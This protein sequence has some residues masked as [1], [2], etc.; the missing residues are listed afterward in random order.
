MEILWNV[1][2]FVLEILLPVLVLL[3]GWGI[4]ALVQ[5]LGVEQQINTEQL[6]EQIVK[7]VID[8]IE[9]LSIAA[10]KQGEQPIA[11][12]D[13]LIT[14]VRLITDEM[15]RLNLPILTGELLRIKIEAY[16]LGKARKDLSVL[17]R[18]R[19]DSP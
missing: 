19:E 1:L 2:P 16:L 8:G 18:G 12:G 6:V 4:R 14:A 3:I 5:K 13:K 9:Q 10:K 17:V 11:G 15:K 7:R